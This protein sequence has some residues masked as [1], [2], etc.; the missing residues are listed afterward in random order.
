MGWRSPGKKRCACLFC[1]PAKM[2][3][4]LPFPGATADS[5]SALPSCNLI[6]MTTSDLTWAL[7][8]ARMSPRSHVHCLW[9]AA[10]R[11]KMTKA[12]ARLHCV[13]CVNRS[14]LTFTTTPGWYQLMFLLETS[15]HETINYRNV[16]PREIL[17]SLWFPLPFWVRARDK[18]PEKR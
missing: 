14:K 5:I 10:A 16:K 4:S 18:L 1:H 2:N 11:E 17:F 3:P 8:D 9:C 6:W 15:S 12:P 7:G 13:V